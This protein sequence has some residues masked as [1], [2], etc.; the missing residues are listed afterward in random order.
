MLDHENIGFQAAGLL[1]RLMQGKKVAT[2]PIIVKPRGISTRRSSDMVAIEDQLT[3]KAVRFIHEHGC[4]GIDVV[5]IATHC[6]VSRRSLE[7]SFN[8][9]AGMSPHDQ[10]VRS[11]L[12]RAKQLLVETNF[13]LDTVA[14]KS[15]LSHAA[16]LNAIFKKMVGLTPGEFRRA[17]AS[18]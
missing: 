6:G 4:E 10:L 1:D 8:Q 11:K 13:P 5:D 14:T 18:R 15:G 16:Y 3:A 2:N 9:F 12:A 7:R 17:A